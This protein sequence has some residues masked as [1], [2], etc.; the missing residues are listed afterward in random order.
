MQVNSQNPEG[1]SIEGLWV[2][3]VPDED[4]RVPVMAKAG[5]EQTYLLGFKNAFKARKFLQE[6]PVEDAEP[7]MVVNANKGEVLNIALSLG[8]AGVLVD[9]DPQTHGYGTATELY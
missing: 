3:L 2:L 8:A 5:D 9:Y 1:A 4:E 7:R 6:T